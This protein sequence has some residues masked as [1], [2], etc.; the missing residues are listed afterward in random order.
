MSFELYSSVDVSVR[1]MFGIKHAFIRYCIIGF[2]Y[3]TKQEKNVNSVATQLPI[4]D[5][6]FESKFSRPKYEVEQNPKKKKNQY[7]IIIE[8]TATYKRMSVQVFGK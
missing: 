2:V 8:A 6:Y 7:E 5:I 3:H 1:L 4:V